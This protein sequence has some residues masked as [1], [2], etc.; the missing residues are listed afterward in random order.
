MK[1]QPN[2]ECLL[3]TVFIRCYIE[4]IQQFFVVLRSSKQSSLDVFL[5]HEEDAF[6]YLNSRNGENGLLDCCFRDNKVT[7]LT[8][9]PSTV[10]LLSTYNIFDIDITRVGFFYTSKLESHHLV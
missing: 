6:S 2:M 4:H 8:S 3:L 7:R 5:V 9:Q 1:R 10:D